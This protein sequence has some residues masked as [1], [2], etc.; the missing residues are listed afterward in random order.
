MRT[1]CLLGLTL[2]ACGGTA[3]PEEVRKGLLDNLPPLAADLN[4]TGES[5]TSGEMAADFDASMTALNA[6]F[7]S[8]PIS[9]PTVGG[10]T[11][12]K[13]PATEEEVEADLRELVEKIFT[14]ANHEGGGVYRVH[15]AVPCDPTHPEYARC[16]LAG[17]R[18]LDFTPGFTRKLDVELS[19]KQWPGH[20]PVPPRA[21][22]DTPPL[23]LPPDA[24]AAF[25]GLSPAIT[26]C[27]A[28]ALAR[29]PDDEPVA[30]LDRIRKASE[31]GHEVGLGV[32]LLD[33][34]FSFGLHTDPC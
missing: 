27:Y 32:R 11:T 33:I 5:V 2:V 14:E 30:I 8:L 13:L 17:A 31:L 18:G 26:A 24:L 29:D 10:S 12:Y 7:P 23:R 6:A 1:W 25:K 19:I 34:S 15:G 21:P 20:A 22:S 4:T 28:T 3:T 16:V 9:M